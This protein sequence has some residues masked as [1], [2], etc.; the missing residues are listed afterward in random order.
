MLLLAPIQVAFG[1]CAALLG[2]DVARFAVKLAYPDNKAVAAGALSALVAFIA[3]SLQYPFKFVASRL[4][5]PPLMISG[6]MSFVGLSLICLYNTPE[7]IA[8]VNCSA[9]A[10][11]NDLAIDTTASPG[12]PTCHHISLLV[13]CY[14]LQG[15]GR[16]CYEGTNKALCEYHRQMPSCLRASA[17][18]LTRPPPSGP[19]LAVSMTGTLTVR[20]PTCIPSSF[21]ADADFFPRHPEAAFSNI[22]L[23]NGVASAV[24]FFSFP[25]LK[26]EDMANVALAASATAIVTYILAEIVHRCSSQRAPQ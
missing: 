9:T 2:N 3:A 16:A 1:I 5:K 6:L 7:A 24:A 10:Q 13:I 14:V 15:I 19:S 22:V 4:G 18:M 25:N 26:T 20:P 8:G 12:L 11:P 21:H 23:A 17:W